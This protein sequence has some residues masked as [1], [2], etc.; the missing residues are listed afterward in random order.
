MTVNLDRF[1]CGYTPKPAIEVGACRACD[2]AIYDYEKVLCSCCDSHIHERCESRC[3]KCGRRGCKGEHGCL[4]EIDGLLYCI[5]CFE[6]KN[7]YKN[8]A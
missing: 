4:K 2:Y 1:S 3:D 6:V 5:E 8:A 7:E